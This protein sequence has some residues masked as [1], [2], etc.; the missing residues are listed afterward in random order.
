MQCAVR[1]YIGL[2]NWKRA[3]LWVQRLSE[4][5]PNTSVQEWHEF[6]KRT[7]HGDRAA[8]QALVDQYR[9]AVGD[10]GQ[11]VAGARN[12]LDDPLDAG[13]SSWLKGATNEATVNLRKVYESDT[14]I[15]AGIALVALAD[16]RGDSK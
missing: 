4:R 14:P 1:C 2:K 12:V 3:E 5:Y 16:E 13:L 15:V 6:C 9:A 7:G 10:T 8:A 11:A